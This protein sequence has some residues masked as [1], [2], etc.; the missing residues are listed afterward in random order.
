MEHRLLQAGGMDSG[1]IDFISAYCD[2]WCERCAF[3]HRCSAFACDLAIGMC[4]GFAEGLE[5]AVGRPQSPDGDEEKPVGERM[6]ADWA[7]T[8]PS[9][10][11][12]AAFDRQEKARSARLDALPLTRM[13]TVYTRRSAQWIDEHRPTLVAHLDPVVREAFAVVCWDAFFIGVKLRRALDGRDRRQHGEE[14]L[15]SWERTLNLILQRQAALSSLIETRRPAS[16]WS[17]RGR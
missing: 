4:G 15:E 8:M 6:V 7:N 12:L 1:R 10:E 14:D 11:E 17:T 5:L 13:S 9:P 16:R 3:T 2:R